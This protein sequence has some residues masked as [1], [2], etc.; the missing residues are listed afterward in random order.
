MENRLRN[1]EHKIKELLAEK[2]ECTLLYAD[3]SS[4]RMSGHDAIISAVKSISGQEPEVRGVLSPDGQTVSGG[5]V[6]ALLR[7]GSEAGI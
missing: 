4:R 5:L 3:G 7:A 1:L 2:H 6:N